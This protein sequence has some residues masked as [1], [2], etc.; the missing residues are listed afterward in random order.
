MLS[1]NEHDVSRVPT[2]PIKVPGIWSDY[3][4]VVSVDEF[5]DL[6]LEH[7]LFSLEMDGVPV[8]ERVRFDVLQAVKQS[9]GEVGR[10][11]PKPDL[12]VRSAGKALSLFLRNLAGKNPF[13]AGSHDYLYFGH[14][15]RKLES[16]GL[17]WDIYCDPIHAAT[18]QD[19][20]HL[21]YPD[22][23]R[24]YR[25]AYTEQLRY[26]DLIDILGIVNGRFGLIGPDIPREVAGPID[27]FEH[28]I[29]RTF[30]C[31]VDV[32]SFISREMRQRSVTFPLYT[33]LIRRVDPEIIFV[34]VSYGRQMETVVEV[35][36]ALGIPVVELQHGVI[37][38]GHLG[39]SYPASTTKHA[40]PDYLFTFGDFWTKQ[41]NFPLDS[42]SIIPIGY[43]YLE[44]ELAASETADDGDGVLFI[45][46]GT[47]GEELSKLA[48]KLA[49]KNP[50]LEI[51]YKL[52]PGEYRNWK[53]TYPWLTGESIT[54]VDS[55]RPPLYEMFRSCGV[56]VGVGST[57]L[58]EGV[59]FG[60][61]TYV[62]GLPG[63]E[64]LQPLV[65][66]GIAYKVN[67]ARELLDHMFGNDANPTPRHDDLFR[68]NAIETYTKKVDE[69]LNDWG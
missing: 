32:L 2:R 67:S 49:E 65:E 26:I 66:E 13:L 45:S 30:G 42:S 38:P 34:V 43:P 59:A 52:H 33:K 29:K 4:D 54:V 11:H 41:A 64:S 6:E 60:L 44:R 23:L 62:V 1:F 16:D 31:E 24:H 9:V 63:S 69:I 20:L 47:I 50:E 15:R 7:D 51:I 58:Y 25:P 56:Q 61:Q 22:F 53:E 40:F 48:I 21:E 28:S 8:W 55:D 27:S 57:A 12:D 46:Q 14:P 10:A 37:H 19:Y 17:W 39:Y 18:T 35:G 5:V 68:R 36:K 3:M